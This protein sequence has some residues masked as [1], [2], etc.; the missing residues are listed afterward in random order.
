MEVFDDEPGGFPEGDA[1]DLG[2]EGE[3]LAVQFSAMGLGKMF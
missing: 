1:A 3:V 2:G